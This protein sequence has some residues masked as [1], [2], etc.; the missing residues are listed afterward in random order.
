MPPEATR[1][2]RQPLKDTDLAPVEKETLARLA[3][4]LYLVIILC[5]VWSEAIVRSGLMHPDDPASTAA[6]IRDHAGLLRLSIA[7]DTLM[8]LADVGLAVVFYA[9]LRPVQ[10]VLALAA[11]AFRLVQAAVIGASLVVLAATPRLAGAGDDV[12]AY[13]F[14]AMHGE[15]YDI[16]LIFFGVNALLMAALLRRSGGTPR[17][18]AL[19]IAAAGAV[20]LAGSYTRLLAPEFHPAILPAYAIPLLAETSFCL[21][22]LIRARV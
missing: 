12:L 2:R 7:A 13:T 11:M 15:G 5:G 19:S 6:A 22:L 9:L 14:F 17:L 1:A 20:Y 21:W 10:P 8:A 4:V 16:G 3:G 18:L